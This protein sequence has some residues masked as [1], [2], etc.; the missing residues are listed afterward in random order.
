MTLLEVRDLHVSFQTSDGLV[1]AVR[2]VS[3]SVDPGQTLGIVGESGSGKSVSTQTIMGL[4]RGAN[5]SGRAV[6]EGRDL[7]TL[8]RE[9]LRTIRGGQIGMIFQ[10][11]LSS[12]HPYYRVGWQIVE[13][14]REHDKSITKNKARARA[15]ELLRLVGIPRPE[16]RIDDFPHQFSGGMRQRAM[17]AMAVALNPKLV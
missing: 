4:T 1:Q 11:P 3:F 7:L 17:I 8:D 13:M 14:I 6:F 9:D 2:G 16:K 15:A 5:I 12:L 10:D